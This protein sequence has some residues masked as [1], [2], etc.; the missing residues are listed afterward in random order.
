MVGDRSSCGSA[1]RIDRRPFFS[2]PPQRH[3]SDQ[4][5][6]EQTVHPGQGLEAGKTIGVAQLAAL[7]F[8]HAF[9]ETSFQNLKK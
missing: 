3:G 6:A 7:G 9:I 2:A 1:R 4:G 5:I 8:C